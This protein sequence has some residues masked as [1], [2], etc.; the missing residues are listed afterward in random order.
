MSDDQNP[1]MPGPQTPPG[2][3]QQSVSAEVV[4][5]DLAVPFM[6]NFDSRRVEDP[7]DPK[8]KNYGQKGSVEPYWDVVKGVHLL[9][10]PVARHSAIA[11]WAKNKPFFF[12]S[13]FLFKNP[14]VEGEYEFD[15][16]HEADHYKPEEGTYFGR[17]NTHCL[18]LEL[19]GQKTKGNF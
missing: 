12:C 3:A 11:V 8:R 18:D 17:Y 7:F 16:D 10:D 13:G 6:D 9:I 4:I 1:N 19:N 14:K 2:P 15:F 5:V